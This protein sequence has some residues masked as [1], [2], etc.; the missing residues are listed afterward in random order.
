MIYFKALCLLVAFLVTSSY[1]KPTAKNELLANI[2]KAYSQVRTSSDVGTNGQSKELQMPS[3]NALPQTRSSG[4]SDADKQAIVDAHNKH[5]ANV[6][7]FAKNMVKMYWDKDIASAAQAWADN[8]EFEHDNNEVRKSNTGLGISIGQNLA[9]AKSYPP[10]AADW[11]GKA[12]DPWYDE[13]NNFAFGRGTTNG[14]QTG[15]Y[16][17]L[18]WADSIAVGCGY[19]GGCKPGEHLY[20]CNY[21]YQQ[22]NDINTPYEPDYSAAGASCAECPNHCHNNLCDCGKRMCSETNGYFSSLNLNTCECSGSNV[23]SYTAPGSGSSS[24]G[25]SGGSSGTPDGSSGG[26][27]SGGSSGGVEIVSYCWDMNYCALYGPSYCYDDFIAKNC[28]CMC[29]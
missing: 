14:L 3:G 26:S 12:V 1:A 13:V 10:E 6:K 27:S 25:S 23:G 21:A 2:A 5:R 19:R 4:V 18:A 8:C 29:R 16:T 28:N 9:W 7:P 20:V 11:V 15:H 17:Q 24:G 22:F